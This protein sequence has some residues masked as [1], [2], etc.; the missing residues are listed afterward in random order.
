MEFRTS[1]EIDSRQKQI[2]SQVSGD[3]LTCWQSQER[4]GNE[5]CVNIL[6]KPHLHVRLKNVLSM[7]KNISYG[8]FTTVCIVYFIAYLLK[9]FQK[10]P[11]YNS[12][13]K[14]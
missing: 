1:Q 12:E 9:C 7:W 14:H 8:I 6:L 3:G 13:S 4:M 2:G 10:G 11:G 5:N